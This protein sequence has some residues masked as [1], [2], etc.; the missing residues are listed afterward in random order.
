[1]E[2]KNQFTGSIYTIGQLKAHAQKAKTAIGQIHTPYSDK[3]QNEVATSAIIVS[4]YGDDTTTLGE[5]HS[6]LTAKAEKQEARAKKTK[7]GALALMAGAAAGIVGGVAL[8][9]S[10]PVLGAAGL[11]AGVYSM[12]GGLATDMISNIQRSQATHNRGIAE[13]V[14]RW[15]KEMASAD[16]AESQKSLPVLGEGKGLTETA[17][18]LDPGTRGA[19]CAAASS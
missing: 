11:A 19:I 1:M 14:T 6:D 12:L 8:V 13:L 10:S 4:S 16:P 18:S 3:F 17:Q 9:A 15:G 7:I 2:V 5:V